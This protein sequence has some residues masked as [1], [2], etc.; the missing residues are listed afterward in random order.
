MTLLVGAEQFLAANSV[1]AKGRKDAVSGAYR[2]FPFANTRVLKLVLAVAFSAMVGDV[3]SLRGQVSP[4]SNDQVKAAFLYN[5]AR[6][7]EWPPEAFAGP[8]DAIN[9]GVVGN[10]AFAAL[11]THAVEGKVVQ[12]RLLLIRKWR[13]NQSPQCCNILFISSS[14]D[15]SLKEILQ[16]IKGESVLTVG[17]TDGFAQQGGMIN[18]ILTDNKVRFEINRK[19]AETAGLKISSKLL[20]LAKTVWE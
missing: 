1:G 5:F 16:K 8:K 2:R 20:A 12:G 6:F 14:L 13:P 15:G 10:D 3:S 7:V 4:L 11:L 19:N 9:I 18:F 17:E